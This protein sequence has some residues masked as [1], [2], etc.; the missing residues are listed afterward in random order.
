MN[1]FN[2]PHPLRVRVPHHSKDK[3]ATDK[4]RWLFL[5]GVEGL[6]PPASCSQSRRATNCATPRYI[7]D[8][9]VILLQFA[10]CH[11][12]HPR[13]APPCGSRNSLLAV[14]FA[15]FRPLH[16]QMLPSSATGGGR[17]CCPK[18]ARYQLRYTPMN[19]KLNVLPKAGVLPVAISRSRVQLHC[20]FRLSAYIL[21]TIH[22]P[23][24]MQKVAVRMKVFRKNTFTL[25]V[26]VV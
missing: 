22:Y 19:I 17:M 16:Q 24:S 2:A 10:G 21:Y 23:L 26:C 14:R 18:Q 7:F 12:R 25:A 20:V 13:F 11:P 8:C 6:E 1:C 5:V 4:C 15:E 3:T 9:F